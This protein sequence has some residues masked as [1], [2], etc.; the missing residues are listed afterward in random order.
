MNIGIGGS[1]YF[2]SVSYQVLKCTRIILID[3]TVECDL[4]SV[5]RKLMKFFLRI[6]RSGINKWN[7]VIR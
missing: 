6:N 1:V 3:D 4:K 2:Y 5:Y 7:L